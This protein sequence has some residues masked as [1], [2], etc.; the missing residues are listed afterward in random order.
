MKQKTKYLQKIMLGLLPLLV[1]AC[2]TGCSGETAQE[3][4]IEYI[5]VTVEDEVFEDKYFFNLLEA[6]DQ[7]VYKEIYQGLINH[8]E[9]ICVH[10]TNI[11]QQFLLLEYISYDFAELFWTEGGAESTSYEGDYSIIEPVYLYTMEER[12]QK[13][14]EIEA[15]TSTILSQIPAEY[16]EY[17]KIKFV[18]EYL[19]NSIEYVE[20]APDNQNIYSAF[21]NK[22]TVCAGYA[23]ANQYLLNELGIFCTYVLGTTSESTAENGGHAWNIVQCGENYYIVDVTWGDTANDEETMVKS[24]IL[25]E[26]LCCSEADIKDTHFKSEE[27]VYPECTAEDLD[28]YQLNHMYYETIDKDALL[29]TMKQALE[30]KEASTIFKFANAELFETAKSK[31]YDDLMVSV[32]NH[33][34][35]LFGLEEMSYYSQESEMFNLLIIYWIYP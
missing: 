12:T 13:E 16:S 33:Y 6:E 30:A 35:D 28:Y 20:D 7:L 31:I 25:Y 14:A 22:Q 2:L 18:Y 9:E 24:E 5:E 1:I 17:E 19:I 29:K 4:E 11:D 23:R 15:A 21:V 34:Y 26:Y 10:G 3:P 8:Q 32:A 27:Y